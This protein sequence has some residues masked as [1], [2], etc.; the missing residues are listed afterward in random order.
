M[1][2]LT[3]KEITELANKPNVKKIAVENFLMSS[4][5][6]RYAEANA[7]HDAKL[8]NWNTETKKAIRTG[9]LKRYSD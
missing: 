5:T 9:L 1:R 3:F 2:E 8:Y 7:E 6:D 4:G